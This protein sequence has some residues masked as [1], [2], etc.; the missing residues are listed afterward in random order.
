MKRTYL[1]VGAL[2][3]DIEFQSDTIE[4]DEEAAALVKQAIEEV[5]RR[6]QI[7]GHHERGYSLKMR[8]RGFHVEHLIED[9]HA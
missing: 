3:I 8:S 1:A 9:A 7:A 2:G 5:V 4:N 6:L